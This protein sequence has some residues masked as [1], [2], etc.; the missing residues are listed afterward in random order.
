M[1][2][3]A[4]IHALGPMPQSEMAEVRM[5]DTLPENLTYPQITPEL[6]TY[7]WKNLELKENRV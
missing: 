4:E 3:H 1:V 5:F 2:F 6:F 7:L